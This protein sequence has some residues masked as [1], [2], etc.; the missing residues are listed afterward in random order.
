MALGKI[1][2]KATTNDFKFLVEVET[3]KFEYIQVNHKTYGKILCQI[4]EME[5]D[6][7]KE[8]AFCTVLGY[9]DEDKIKKPR[10]PFEIGSEVDL[11]EDEFIKEI[12]KLEN[13][14]SGA[15]IGKLDGKEIDVHL[16]LD[17]VLTMH[18]SILAKSGAGKS[19]SVGVILE[20]MISK[21]IP[22]IV[23]D[24]HG[25]YSTLKFKNDNKDDIKKLKT[26]DLK[27]QAFSVQEFGDTTVIP[28]VRPIRLNKSSD[29]EEFLHL[30]P[31]KLTNSQLAILYSAL[32]NSK[33]TDFKS[34]LLALDA[35]E[36]NAK[37]SIISMIEHLNNLNLFSDTPISYNEF[38][39]PGCCSIINMKGINPEIQE[40]IVYKICSDMFELRKKGKLPPFFMIIEEAHNYCPERSFGETKASKI[41][42]SIASEGRKF[43]LGLCVISQRPARVDKSILSQCSTQFVLKVTNPNDLKAITSSIEGLTASTEQEIQNLPI[44]TALI[45]GLTEVPLFVNI[46]PRKSMHGGKAQK[47]I[48][49][50][51]FIEKVTAFQEKQVLPIIKPTNFSKTLQEKKRTILVPCYN[52]VCSDNTSEFNLLVETVNGGIVFDKDNFKTKIIPEMKIMDDKKINILRFAFKKNKFKEQDLLSTL[53]LNLAVTEELKQLV[54]IGYLTKI[55]DIYSLS[56]KYVFSKLSNQKNNYKIESEEIQYDEKL[57]QKVTLDEII[58]KLRAF[59]NIKDRAECFLVLLDD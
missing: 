5:R 19:Y 1:T 28:G 38:L 10:I 37:W 46:R 23:F 16:D 14:E 57:V 42:R 29:Q 27:T 11:A 50:N 39:K 25:E 20:E 56:D 44:G 47:M 8:I 31:G 58:N 49:N 4:V 17:K 33:S 36:S 54:K 15:H 51:N 7:D 18:L 12:I 26:Y 32:K 13:A 45:T 24:P 48:Q 21:N 53:G 3:K 34:I 35:E 55:S 2:G 6:E 41:I 30:L 59:T 22:L 40:L 9:K 43:G 52:F